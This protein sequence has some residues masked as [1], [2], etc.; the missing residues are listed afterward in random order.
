MN[1][2]PFKSYTGYMDDLRQALADNGHLVGVAAGSGI[3]A[4]YA[5]QGG[6][7]LIMA[8]HGLRLY[9]RLSML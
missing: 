3:T 2:T 8:F 4:K 6:C 9:G 5:I 7:N 1:H